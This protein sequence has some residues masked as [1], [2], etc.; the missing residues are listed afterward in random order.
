[1]REKE[2]GAV[3]REELDDVVDKVLGHG[4]GTRAD[5]DRQ[6]QLTLR[7]HGHPDPLGRPLQALNGLSLADLPGLDGPEEGEEFVE[8]HLLDPYLV[9]EV[10]REGLQ[11][12]RR[13]DQPLQHRVRIDLKHPRRAAD[14]QS[15]SQARDDTH[16]EVD[17]GALPMKDRAEGLQK[18]AATSDT[19]QLTPGT[20]I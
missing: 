5:V 15:L 2:W 16:D 12:L 13:V 9:Q 6:Q 7:V 1:I 8:L 3:G 11:L 20:A 18:V 4:Q 10:L 17:G 14:A 19:Q